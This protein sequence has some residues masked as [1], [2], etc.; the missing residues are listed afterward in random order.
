MNDSFSF[1]NFSQSVR[2]KHRLDYI[3]RYQND[4]CFEPQW[5]ELPEWKSSSS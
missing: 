1:S 3:V 4:I 2:E 5:V